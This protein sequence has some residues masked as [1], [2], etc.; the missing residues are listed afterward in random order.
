MNPICSICYEFVVL[1]I[2]ECIFKGVPLRSTLGTNHRHHHPLA[3]LSLFPR[4]E[5]L[6][7]A[8]DLWVSLLRYAPEC[9]WWEGREKEKESE[10]R[11]RKKEEGGRKGRKRERAREKREMERNREK[12]KEGGRQRESRER[13]GRMGMPTSEQSFF[14][15][16]ATSSFWSHASHQNHKSHMTTT[17]GNWC[18]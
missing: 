11:R 4:E 1:K 5:A 18:V 6:S 12:E 16:A 8:T 10:E 13:E 14:H 7:W 3:T 2:L 15:S 17:S 9:L